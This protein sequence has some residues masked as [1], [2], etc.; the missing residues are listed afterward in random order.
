MKSFDIYH[1]HVF[2]LEIIMFFKYVSHNYV[3]LLIFIKKKKLV[4]KYLLYIQYKI[5]L[6]NCISSIKRLL[7]H[8]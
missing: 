4:F 6:E 8:G 2:L 5:N 1:K 3:F 7:S